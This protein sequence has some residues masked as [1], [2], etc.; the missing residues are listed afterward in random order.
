MTKKVALI[1]GGAKRVGRVIAETLHEAGYNV[2]IHYN[3]SKDQA[4]ELVKQLNNKRPHSAVQVAAD[5][6]NINS[7]SSLINAVIAPWQRLDLVVNN[8]SSFF[9]TPLETASEQQWNDLMA[10]NVKGPYFLILSARL[11][12]ARVNGAVVNITDI[13]A[14][15]PLKHYSLYCIMKAGLEMLTKSLAK[16]LAPHVRVNAVAPGAILW[17]EGVNALDEK[18]QEHIIAG[19]LLQRHG[20]PVD[21]AR[22]VCYL[23]EAGFVTGQTLCVD[24]GRLLK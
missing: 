20:G 15:R 7:F 16:E 23:A 24:G 1:T 18:Q 2:C 10:S 5:L 4:T 8:A 21:V 17:P 6:A 3:H 11:A 22:A 12:L 9:P 14:Q 19:T 13:H